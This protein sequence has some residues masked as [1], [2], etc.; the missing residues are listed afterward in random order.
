LGA[1]GIADF[2]WITD[3][4]SIAGEPVRHRLFHYRLVASGWAYAQVVYGGESFS[5]LADG[6]QKAFRASGGV[7]Y[8]LRTDSLSAAYKN[9]EE[10]NDFTERFDALC[11]H[12]GLKPSRN[13]RGVAHA[14][15]KRSV[16]YQH[17][18][19]SL[20]KKPRA[21][22]HSKWRADLLPNVD[23][24]RI[25][26]HVD[27]YLGADDASLYI[28]RLLHLAKKG[29]CEDALG[30][31][32][33]A[34]LDEHYLPTLKQC[35]ERFLDVHGAIPDVVVRQHAL[36]SYQALLSAGGGHE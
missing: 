20:V 11:Q 10:Q 6:L 33:V 21:F 2:T 18:I 8:E 1:L 17:V 12:Y 13:N 27:R 26:G 25:W 28:V 23:Y 3:P 4:V 30:R 19:E 36:S 15:R 5:A 22:R 35:E 34:A 9:R 7:P 29:D 31:Y 24:Q 16:N 14:N 32:V